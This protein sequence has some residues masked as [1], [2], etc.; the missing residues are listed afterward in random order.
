MATLS[1]GTVSATY[2]VRPRWGADHVVLP[3]A[4]GYT[5]SATYDPGGR[6]TSITDTRVEHPDQLR[7]HL[8]CGGQSHHAS[9]LTARPTPT[10]TTAEPA[11]QGL[12]RHSCTAGSITYTYDAD[13]QPHPMTDSAG[14]HHLHL[15]RR[16]R[17]DLEHRVRRHAPPTPTMPTAGGRRRGRPPTSWNAADELTST[18][19]RRHHHL[20]LR[21]RR[22]PGL[23]HQRVGTTQLLLRP[24]QPAC[25]PGPRDERQRH[26]ARALHLGRRPFLAV[27]TGGA[28]YYVAHDAQGSVGRAHHATGAT[29]AT[30]TY[31]PFG[32]LRSTTKTAPMHP[33]CPS[34]SRAS[35]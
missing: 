27:H 23:G 10:P 2:G 12:L 32:N 31:D 4:N 24:R 17:A 29:E 16:Q 13:G 34:A 9:S 25:P 14:H 26:R 22:Q 1:A 28:D 5:E 3:A 8:R 11:H 20:H 7:L 35:S 15:R 6:M 18:T 21:R 33:A 30:Y 19:G